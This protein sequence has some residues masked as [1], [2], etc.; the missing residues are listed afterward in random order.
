MILYFH[1]FYLQETCPPD[2]YL[3]FGREINIA[4]KKWQQ[5][6]YHTVCKEAYI[7]CTVMREV[8]EWFLK[9]FANA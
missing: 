4:L 2:C 1:L 3:Y 5:E 9:S 8:K 6:G 7:F